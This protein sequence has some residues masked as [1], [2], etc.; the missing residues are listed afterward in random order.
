MALNQ[1]SIS[2]FR[3]NAERQSKEQHAVGNVLTWIGYGLVAAVVLIAA[4]AALGGY[5][6]KKMIDSQSVSIQQLDDRYSVQLAKS[7]EERTQMR[8]ELDRMAEQLAT[9]TN[10]MAKQQEQLKRTASS[11]D[12]SAA[13]L[14]A[15]TRE[16]IDLRNRV[17]RLEGNRSGR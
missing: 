5:T 9:A 16:I 17:N 2:D 7:Q 1:P 14:K 12:D 11:A 4:M 13:I 6:L 8:T 10:L 15:R 3:K